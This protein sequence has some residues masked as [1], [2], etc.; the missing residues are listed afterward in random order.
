MTRDARPPPKST[1]KVRFVGLGVLA[2]SV[3]GY[4]M[5]HAR[6]AVPPEEVAAI[7]EWATHEATTY[8]RGSC[9]RPVLRGE[10]REGSGAARLGALFSRTGPGHFCFASISEGLHQRL[11]ADLSRTPRVP[12]DV[13]LPD[14]RAAA[15]ACEELVREVQE[16]VAFGSICTPFPPGATPPD[17]S[18]LRLFAS[19]VAVVAR[20]WARRGRP[21]EAVELLLDGVRAMDDLLR[22][23]AGEKVVVG[24]PAA[25]RG[26]REHVDVILFDRVPAHAVHATPLERRVRG[27]ADQ[28]R[29]LLDDAPFARAPAAASALLDGLVRRGAVARAKRDDTFA[30]HYRARRD[31]Y[32]RVLRAHSDGGVPHVELARFARSATPPPPP[33]V[34][35]ALFGRRVRRADRLAHFERGH[36]G[37]L[38]ERTL[39]LD[40]ARSMLLVTAVTLV[41][42]AEGCTHP[43]RMPLRVTSTDDGREIG[44][45]RYGRYETGRVSGCP[46]R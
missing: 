1:R 26:L 15:A 24:I 34:A 25:V 23:G 33:A 8:P 11:T 10:T 46:A 42:R 4:V 30:L 16:V 37:E 41:D 19:A 2:L 20:D 21:F 12:L 29:A 35:I 22:G 13:V 43:I 31:L 38:A 9:E 7:H 44:L 45:G 28:A 39:S 18:R 32:E 36:A 14:E 6:R 5:L 17:E 27:L 3:L 40:F